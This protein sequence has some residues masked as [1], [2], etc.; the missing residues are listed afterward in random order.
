M[1]TG[2]CAARRDLPALRRGDGVA[3][4]DLPVP[5]LQVQDRL[6]RRRDGR[7]QDAA[8]GRFRA[9]APW[10][11]FTSDHGASSTIHPSPT[12]ATTSRSPTRSGR[13]RSST[14]F[15]PVPRPVEDDGTI[16]IQQDT[17]P[18]GPS[19]ASR[20]ISG[21]GSCSR[22]SGSCSSSCSFP[23]G[24][25]LAGRDDDESAAT[26]TTGTL[27]TTTSSTHDDDSDDDV[28]RR[29]HRSRG[30]RPDARRGTSAARASNVQVRVR[31][32][33]SE[34]L[35]AKCSSSR[36]APGARLSADTVVILTVSKTPVPE[37]VTVPRVEGLLDERGGVLAA[38]SG[39]RRG[40]RDRPLLAARG[41]GRQ[42]DVRSRTK[43]SHRGR[44][45]CSRWPAPPEPV[46]VRG[47]TARRPRGR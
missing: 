15:S 17:R 34:D 12:T 8:V 36:P 7:V 16:V 23:T 2:A 40:D 37:R 44:S 5:A 10:A 45:S 30:H 1:S 43:R 32:V 47:A 24:I 39:A 19:A 26:P 25:W 29:E 13:S 6:L 4:R 33:P 35:R 38:P 21:R 11:S 28:P 41:N 42:P 27:D 20:P 46:T 3:P 31:R 9:H 18:A 22:C 14:A